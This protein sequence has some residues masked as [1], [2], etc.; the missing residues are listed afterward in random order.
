MIERETPKNGGEWLGNAKVYENN[1]IASEKIRREAARQGNEAEAEEF[2]LKV[3]YWRNRRD[4]EQR[5]L[6]R[7]QA[8]RFARNRFMGRR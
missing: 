4:T 3:T 7:E 6:E 2:A 8:S 1:R 5:N